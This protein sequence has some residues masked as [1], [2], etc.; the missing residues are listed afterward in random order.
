MAVASENPQTELQTSKASAHVQNDIALCSGD[1]CSA[2][3]QVSTHRMLVASAG[4]DVTTKK[5]KCYWKPGLETHIVILALSRQWQEDQIS[6]TRMHLHRKTLSGK[7]QNKKQQRSW[8]WWLTPILLALGRRNQ[9]FK[10]ILMVSWN[11][12][13]YMNPCLK[14]YRKDMCGG[15][16]LQSQH[17]E[18]REAGG[19][20]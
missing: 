1:A 13:G 16:H 12:G 9:R 19:S 14:K 8:G 10:V 7:K 17:S 4:Q 18:D 11:A 20:L 2:A 15:P 6:E 3:P 5:K